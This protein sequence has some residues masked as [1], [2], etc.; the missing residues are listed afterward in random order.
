[1]ME[2]SHGYGREDLA[3]LPISQVCLWGGRTAEPTIQHYC[4]DYYKETEFIVQYRL[5][6]FC[7]ALHLS[8]LP[9]L[10]VQSREKEMLLPL[11]LSL[12]QDLTQVK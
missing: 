7:H 9:S 5:L 3:P 1:M 6:Y 10:P 12:H 11:Y 4:N 8:L 2:D